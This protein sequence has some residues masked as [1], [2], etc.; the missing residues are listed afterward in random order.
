MTTDFVTLIDS[1]LTSNFNQLRLEHVSKVLSTLEPLRGV[2]PPPTGWL[3]AIREALGRTG[4]QQ[5][6]RVGIA[7]PNLHKNEV[8]EAKGGIT[9]RQL[10]KLADALDCELVYGLIPRR[11]LS[12]VVEARVDQIAREEVFGVLHSMSLE[13]QGTTSEFV[14]RQLAERRRELLAGNWSK[15]WR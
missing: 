7:G 3:R 9:L 13:D 10:R 8:A 1:T 2:R 11:P 14:E 4:R 12:E 15:L 6:K 5:A